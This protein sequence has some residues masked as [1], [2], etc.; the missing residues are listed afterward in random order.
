MLDY[1]TVLRLKYSTGLSGTQI[2]R[3]LGC[4][5]TGVN[6]FLAAFERCGTLG[7]SLPQGITN[8][9]IYVAVYGSNT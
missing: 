8:E 9:G 1:K 4:S 3:E 7:Y 6:D 5:K 2:A